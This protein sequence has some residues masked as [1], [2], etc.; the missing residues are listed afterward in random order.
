MLQVVP[1]SPYARARPPQGV[2]PDSPTLG[3]E[4]RVSAQSASATEIAPTANV[5]APLTG[6]YEDA[7]DGSVQGRRPGYPEL[8]GAGDG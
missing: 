8:I 7:V 6:Y 2:R 1:A 4:V 5:S 3:S